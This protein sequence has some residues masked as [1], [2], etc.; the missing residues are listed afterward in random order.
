M[1]GGKGGRND[2]KVCV[3]GVYVAKVGGAGWGWRGCMAWWGVQGGGG[4]GV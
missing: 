3:W 2:M 1:Q 4:G